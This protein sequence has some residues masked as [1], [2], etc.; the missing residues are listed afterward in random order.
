[1]NNELIGTR[2]AICY[3]CGD[4]GDLIYRDLPDRVYGVGGFWDL[5]KCK[6]PE[7][8]STWLDPMPLES[9]LPKAYKSYYTHN[10]VKGVEHGLVDIRGLVRH[11]ERLWLAIL[12]LGRQRRA[13]DTMFIE[14]LK[15]GRLL[16]VGCGEGKFLLAM[17]QL[18]WEVEGQDVDPGAGASVPDTTRIHVHIGD[19]LALELP[20]DHYD[21]IAMNHVIEHVYDPITLIRRCFRLLRPGGTLV[22]TTPN[23]ES[24]GH[25]LFGSAW[26]GL[27]VPRHLRLF[28]P[29]ALRLIAEEADIVAPQTWT[30]PA[31]AGGLLAASRDIKVTGHHAPRS[32]VTLRQVL[33]AMWYQLLARLAFARNRGSGEESVLKASKL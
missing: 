21:V 17:H 2:C 16:E 27:E 20:A 7:C 6:N 23:P 24:Y 5:R 28:P 25:T 8:G 1:M 11:L 3:V 26:I 14:S 29:Q 30:T 18:G 32:P 31:R 19:L 9:E 12:I 22:I 10:P 13:V 4:Q 33:T 15:P